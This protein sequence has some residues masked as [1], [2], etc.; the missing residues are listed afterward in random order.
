MEERIVGLITLQ[1]IDRTDEEPSYR[2]EISFERRDYVSFPFL[3]GKVGDKVEIV[4]YQD[5]GGVE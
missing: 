4:I 1:R 5:V 3:W 2:T